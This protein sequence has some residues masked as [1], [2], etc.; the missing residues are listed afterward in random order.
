MADL[1]LHTA[2]SNDAPNDEQ[3]KALHACIKKVTD[4]LEGMRFNTAISALMVF[5]NEAS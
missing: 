1:K 5:V 3:L 4:D 2:I